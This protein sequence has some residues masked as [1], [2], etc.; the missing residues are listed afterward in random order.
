MAK[1]Q[2]IPTPEQIRKAYI[3]EHLKRNPNAEEFA[4]FSENEL[5]AFIRKYEKGDFGSIYECTD[6]HFYDRIRKRIGPDDD[7]RQEDDDV[8]QKY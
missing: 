7:M 1:K 8:G 6:H 4:S 3:E 2:L 5:V